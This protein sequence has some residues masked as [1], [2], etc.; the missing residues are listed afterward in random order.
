M[1]LN[2]RALAVFATVAMGSSLLAAC[3]D[4]GETKSATGDAGANATSA[5]IVSYNG[6]EPRN[7]FLPGLANE[8]CVV[9]VMNYV[10]ARLVG[11][12]VDGKM[13][14]ELAESVES[15]D[16]K[17]WTIKVK[18]G[19]KFSDGTPINADSFINA[20]NYIVR[21]NQT[22]AFFFENV[23][24]YEPGK[25]LAGLKK[26]DD[27]T[28][29]VELNQAESDFPLRL[30]FVVY[31]PLP[32]VAFKD[33][34][35]F[36]EKPVSSGPYVVKEWVHQRSVTMDVNPNYDGPRKAKNGGLE[37]RMYTSPDTAYNDLLGGNLDVI[38]T[39]PDSALSTVKTDL[40]G[41]DISRSMAGVL[42]IGIDMTT[43]HFQGEEGK[44]RRAAISM[45]IN[46]EEVI[47]NIFDG[48]KQ[49]AEDFTSPAVDGWKSGLPGSEVLKFNPEK[50]K[51]LWAKAE[52]IS[53]F[54][55]PFKVAYNSDGGNQG[56]VDAI[57][58]QVKNNLGVAAEGESFPDYK[59]L[60]G[61][62]HD[63]TL[64]G[65]F[66]AN[67]TADYPSQYNFLGP[68]YASNADSNRF[69]YKNEKFDAL[70]KQGLGENDPKAAQAKYAEA[71]QILLDE[72]PAI[73]LWYRAITA[74]YSSKVS[75][76]KFTGDGFPVLSQV[77]K[78]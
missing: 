44:L 62:I 46:R 51:E 27:Q 58:N 76:V 39:V 75:N 15:T 64:K 66:R 6:C 14:N 32:E 33:M 72:L 8:T 59:S 49:P 67:W 55:G 38:S 25:D 45:A 52:A 61:A 57:C 1:K 30:G 2:N 11:Y 65:A 31:A 34:K 17:T 63:L 43:P 12:D 7:P 47:K 56:W 18:A 28:F 78:P 42:A 35:A 41:R 73:P 74:G 71:Q 4:A 3:S 77:Q 40:E 68:V 37:Y 29:T 50:A 13:Y 48:T 26:V 36:G 53:K 10:N 16:N 60:A 69:N 54:E 21:E 70:L 24:G 23:A 9:G 19:Q 20:W 22:Q 5:G